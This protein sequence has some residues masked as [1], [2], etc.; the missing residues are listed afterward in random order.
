[1]DELAKHVPELPVLLTV[2]VCLNITN[3]GTF[4]VKQEMVVFK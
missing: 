2:T 3:M 4:P 1:M